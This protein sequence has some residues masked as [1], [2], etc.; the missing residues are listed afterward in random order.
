MKNRVL[1]ENN[2]LPGELERPICAFVDHYNTHRHHESL[3]NLTPADVYH[4][5]RRKRLK[6]RVEIKKRRLQHQSA[7][8]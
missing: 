8:A 7:A 6:M 4:G 3:D 2:F 5:G 1:P